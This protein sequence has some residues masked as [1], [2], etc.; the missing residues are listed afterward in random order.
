LLWE[1]NVGAPITLGGPSIGNGMLLVGTEGSNE[2]D[3]NPGCY[4]VA[5]GFPSGNRTGLT[6]DQLM[7][8]MA[9][10]V[11]SSLNGNVAGQTG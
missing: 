9:R 1:F 6:E 2:V 10:Q 7:D 3:F 5:F 8:A 11:N 4:L